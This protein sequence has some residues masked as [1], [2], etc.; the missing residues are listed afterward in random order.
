MDSGK[1]TEDAW[2]VLCEL[3]EKRKNTLII[4]S[5]TDKAAL[6]LRIETITQE[7]M[8][9][10]EQYIVLLEESANALIQDEK[11]AQN[12]VEA[13][14]QQLNAY[15]KQEGI[16]K[17]L[18]QK[19][20]W[21]GFNQSNY[22]QEEA[23]QEIRRENYEYLDDTR[24][25]H[26]HFQKDAQK[27]YN[28]DVKNREA[29]IKKQKETNAYKAKMA[30]IDLMIARM[31]GEVS[32]ENLKQIRDAYDEEE[33]NSIFSKHLFDTMSPSEQKW[34]YEHR[35]KFVHTGL[36]MYEDQS[37]YYGILN[38]K[39][40]FEQR[41]YRNSYDHKGV[42]IK[43]TKSDFPKPFREIV[44]KY[45]N[46]TMK[47]LLRC[48]LQNKAPDGMDLNATPEQKLQLLRDSFGFAE[49][50]SLEDRLFDNTD[51]INAANVIRDALAKK[52]GEKFANIFSVSL[53]DAVAGKSIINIFDEMNKLKE[54]LS[55]AKMR[56]EDAKKMLFTVQASMQDVKSK[57][58][59]YEA[60]LVALKQDS[61]RALKDKAFDAEAAK[62]VVDIYSNDYMDHMKKGQ[63][64]SQNKNVQNVMSWAM[65]NRKNLRTETQI[66]DK[67]NDTSANSNILR[68]N[69]RKIYK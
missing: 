15:E 19:A 69:M 63:E 7:V 43:R 10:V 55:Q 20:E 68:K 52:T 64:I 33:R 23:P 42:V 16:S 22:Q 6:D 41:K 36:S 56:H 8:K 51:R 67:M 13:S 62:N 31:L 17:D 26:K 45:P 27:K 65:A 37:S 14:A 47:E 18:F 30:A 29:I 58:R 5:E 12:E 61:K 60:K 38:K 46:I 25:E 49:K 9:K 24:P 54:N 34:E 21:G 48:V 66:L 53:N 59:D 1:E 57:K 3:K 11:K 44:E 28:A 40:L 4:L 35:T 2:A 50:I 32:D 39:A